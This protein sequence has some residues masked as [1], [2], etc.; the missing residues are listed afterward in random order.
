[1]SRY[2][3]SDI[4][5]YPGTTVLR[6]KLNIRD[7]SELDAFEADVTALRMLELLDTPVQGCFDLVHLCSIHHH[8]FQDVYEWAGQL[9]TVDISRGSSR[10]AH[11]SLIE[12]YLGAGLSQLAHENW[13][14]GLPPDRM[15]ERLA[16][17]MG[18]INA[19][20]P[21]REGNG[22]AQRL[23]CAQLAEQA[24]YFINFESVDQTTMYQVMV[25]S[26]NGDAKPLECLFSEIMAIIEPNRPGD[27]DE[28]VQ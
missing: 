10:F 1:M 28:L 14:R 24:G 4:Y 7:Q 9:R 22:R 19:T 6:N 2:D 12:G 25:A 20:H 27:G 8:V 16:H 17:Y 13:L 18:E 3:A 23:F 26:F 21:F 15:A 11:A 5:A